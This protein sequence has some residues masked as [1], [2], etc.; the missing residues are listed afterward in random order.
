M[1]II[2]EEEEREI[3]KAEP[4]SLGE[5]PVATLEEK[6]QFWMM[7][8]SEPPETRTAPPLE[9]EEPRAKWIPR[10]VIQRV[11]TKTVRARPRP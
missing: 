7:V 6:E 2:V 10:T 4:P 1:D 3:I 11:S 5:V 8:L 9:R